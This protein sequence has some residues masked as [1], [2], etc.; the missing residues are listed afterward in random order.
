MISPLPVS[1]RKAPIPKILHFAWVGSS[2]PEWVLSR[3]SAWQE[4]C[5]DWDFKFWTD[6]TAG[7]WPRSASLA[8]LCKHPAILV[9]YISIETL[10]RFGGVYMDSDSWPL[11][12][13]DDLAGDR[14]AWAS[15]LHC[16]PKDWRVEIGTGAFGFPSGHPFLAAVWDES[17]RRL[18]GRDYSRWNFYA[19]PPVWTAEYNRSGGIDLLPV[20][21]FNPLPWDERFKKIPKLVADPD[22]ARRQFPGA[23]ALHEYDQSWNNL[24]GQVH[25][26]G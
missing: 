15:T 7:Q 26:G 1:L 4:N 6:E 5:P 13:L 9:D 12:S 25:S 20:E 8:P 2:V 24:T 23:Y 16:P 14:L 11:R 17:V 3:W 10:A 21:A 18:H 19:G 22:E